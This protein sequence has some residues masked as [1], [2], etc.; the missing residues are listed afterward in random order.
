MFVQY[1]WS[2]T[3]TPVV[4]GARR[5][6]DVAPRRNV[7]DPI[8]LSRQNVNAVAV[9]KWAEPVVQPACRTHT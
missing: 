4:P 8:G 1:V 7:Q 5:V 2:S 9:V 6:T 3:D